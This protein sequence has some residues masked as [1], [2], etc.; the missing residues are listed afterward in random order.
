MEQLLNYLNKELKDTDTELTKLT[1]GIYFVTIDTLDRISTLLGRQ[2]ELKVTLK[3]VTEYMDTTETELD[4]DMTHVSDILYRILHDALVDDNDTR[5]S[6]ATTSPVVTNDIKELL[7]LCYHQL[8]DIGEMVF[9]QSKY[10]YL[11]IRYC[12]ESECIHIATNPTPGF[13]A[14]SKQFLLDHID[15]VLESYEMLGEVL[16]H[17]RII[18][19][20][21]LLD[22]LRHI[23]KNDIVYVGYSSTNI[24]TMAVQKVIDGKVYTEPT[25]DFHSGPLSRK[26]VI[27][28]LTQS[29]NK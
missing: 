4:S 23:C 26:V 18:D 3:T 24:G 29:L 15:S 11:G 16:E 1:S 8:V 21:N 9:K 14:I 25:Y 20:V 2:E 12:E 17:S 19:Q 13:T 22:H 10:R 6:T 7:S 5:E 28:L 27:D